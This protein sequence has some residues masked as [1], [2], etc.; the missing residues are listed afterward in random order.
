MGLGVGFGMAL[1][2]ANVLGYVFTLIL[3]RAL[4]PEQFGAFA[5]VNTLGLVLAIPIGTLQIIVGR[6][7]PGHGIPGL[8]LGF[9]VGLVLLALG[10]VATPL[11][12][13]L[14]HL[15][16]WR[17]TALAMANLVPMAVVGAVSG[18]VLGRNRLLALAAVTVTTAVLRVG[19]AVVVSVAGLDVDGVFASLLV[20]GLLACGPALWLARHELGEL[21]RHLGRGIVLEVLRSSRTM[22]G[23]VLLS[24]ADVLLARHFLPADDAG[25]YALAALLGRLVFWGTQF[26][27]LTIVPALHPT[28]QRRR[29][30][31]GASLVLVLGAA[32]AAVSLAAPDRL[33]RLFGGAAYGDAA[34]LLF[35]FTVLGTLHGLAQVLLYA[36]MALGGGWLGGLTWVVTVAA[37]AVV[38]LVE[39]AHAFRILAVFLVAS[40]VVVLVGLQRV[41]VGRRGDAD[42]TLE[43]L[44][45]LDSPATTT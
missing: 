19:A 45:A 22:S 10:L 37:V 1:G 13:S 25:G 4:G 20:A 30:L 33:I 15:D 27:A 31:E 12:T 16:S 40:L 42:G 9:A 36:E 28:T 43:P 38:V 11:A 8:R 39:H 24:S 2:I 32:A 17:T 3:T 41:A 18:Q 23:L 34:G 14:F 21:R 29:I 44:D 5:A 7:A 35:W 6:R 26:V